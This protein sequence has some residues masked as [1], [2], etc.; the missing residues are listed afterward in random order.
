M[1]PKMIH[2]RWCAIA[3]LSAVVLYA[4]AQQFPPPQ[5]PGVSLPT[6]KF[7]MKTALGSFKLLG[8]S[9]EDPVRGHFE[10]SFTGTILVSGLASGG[11]L[12]TSG[13][14]REEYSDAKHNKREFFGTGKLIVD[15]TVRSIQWFGRDL[16]GSFE[17]RGLLRLY[18]EFDKQ[19]KTGDYW[20]GAPTDA[21]AKRIPWGTTGMQVEVPMS[22]YQ[23]PVPQIPTP[24]N[25]GG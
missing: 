21:N 24:R 8:H 10:V 19:S 6:G 15:G 14:V 1:M 7:S 4:T 3:S 17:G 9:D 16:V 2:A 12:V 18:G 25:H 23:R 5:K 11:K 13:N 22:I 20:F